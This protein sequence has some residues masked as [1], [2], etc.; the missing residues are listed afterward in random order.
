MSLFKKKSTKDEETKVK[1][2]NSNN[3]DDCPMCHIPQ[4]IV[5]QLKDNH[6]EE[7]NNEK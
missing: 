2:N 5:D 3:I 7:E 4:E 1:E 6:Q